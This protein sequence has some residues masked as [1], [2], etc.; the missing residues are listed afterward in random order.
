MSLANYS[1]KQEIPLKNFLQNQQKIK[2]G[3]IYF[4]TGI[5]FFNL[6]YALLFSRHIDK[7]EICFR[8]LVCL[9]S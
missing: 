1:R 6:A 3:G 8:F 5:Y 7:L 9:P 4:C 2:Y